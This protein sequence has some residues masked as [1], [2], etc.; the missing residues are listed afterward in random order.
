MQGIITKGIGGFYYIKTEDGLYEC[1]ARGKFRLDELTPM[2]GDK[3]EIEIDNNS[4]GTIEKI[5]ERK[6]K[7]IRPAVSNIS[8]AIIVF[9]FKNP[10]INLDLLN[11]FLLQCEYNEINAVVAFNKVDLVENPE[12]EE[13]VDIIKS[14]GY[15][16]IYLNAK[17]GMGIEKIR[18]KLKGNLN[19][20]CGPSGAGKST[21]I[22]KLV[23][24]DVMETGQISE[25]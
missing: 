8:Q 19:V 12:E 2:V 18:E 1:K 13:V 25:N 16:V 9:A 17:E 5:F 7:L 20:L 24:K 14:A 6:N 11:K 22:N 21:I 4:K 15:E 23:G 10:N 3:V